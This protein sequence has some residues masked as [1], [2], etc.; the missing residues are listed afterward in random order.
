VPALIAPRRLLVVVPEERKAPAV[1][2]A[3]EGPVTADCP[4][5]ILQRQAHAVL[6]LDRESSSLLARR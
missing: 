3:L 6:Y 4:A 5:S 2:A 1:R